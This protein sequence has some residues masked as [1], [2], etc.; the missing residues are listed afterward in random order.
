[1]DRK[2]EQ[3]TESFA[4]NAGILLM[5]LPSIFW[6]A[7]VLDLTGLSNFLIEHVIVPVDEASSLLTIFCLVVLPMITLVINLKSLFAFR[8]G[9]TG[10][11][12]V[13]DIHI[14]RNAF[15][16]LLVIYAGLSIVVLMSYAFTENFQI[17]AR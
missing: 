11:D 10:D 7:V 16:W 12:M 1:M 17:V 4:L 9:N 3:R 2:R 14:H 5:A 15:Q 8:L 6:A 13:L